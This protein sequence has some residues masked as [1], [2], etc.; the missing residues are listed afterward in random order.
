MRAL[1]RSFVLS[2]AFVLPAAAGSDVSAQ[3]VQG[4]VTVENSPNEPIEGA[5]V[6]LVD[7]A[8]G[9]AAAAF[10]T[11]TGHFLLN[12]REEG[13]YRIRVDRIGFGSWTSE[14]FN[15]T[16]GEPRSVQYGL[17]IRPVQLAEL[18]ISVQRQCWDGL[19][20]AE[21]L[22]VVWEEARK[23]LATTSF[24]Q[25]GESLR[26][27][28]LVYDRRFTEWDLG[29][30]LVE[31]TELDGYTRTPFYS[32][33]AAELSEGGYIREEDAA[34]Y[35]YAPDADV[36][37]SDPFLSDHC[38]G[39]RRA[40]RDGLIEIGLTFD[41]PE[42]RE[43]SDISGVI[44]LNEATA[45]LDRLEF[46]YENIPYQGVDDRRIGG[47]IEFIRIPNGPFVVRDWHLKMPVIAHD[48]AQ[49]GRF[50]VTDF[51]E[52]GGQ[53]RAVLEASGEPVKWRSGAAIAGFVFDS[54][55]DTPLDGATLILDPRRGDN[56]MAHTGPDGSFLFHGLEPGEYRV[57]LGH[58]RAHA[59][60]WSP[61][62]I[63]VTLAEGEER[64]IEFALPSAQAIVTRL[65][66]KPNPGEGALVG[67]VREGQARYP[68]AR[69]RVEFEWDLPPEPAPVVA[70][71]TAAEVA[72]DSTVAVPEVRTRSRSTVAD[73]DGRFRLCDVPTGIEIRIKA[74]RRSHTPTRM[75][76]T[77][78]RPIEILE[79]NLEFSPGS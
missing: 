5:F 63:S 6:V 55:S 24:V 53:I 59:L 9:S 71:D 75:T 13:T 51:T 47:T 33:P 43:L 73:Q 58:P 23:A 1:L 22:L 8:G 20:D 42:D 29:A 39:L 64:S 35:Y 38:F 65:C 60:R 36:L 10:T 16:G 25:E 30:Q 56:V 19:E 74:E 49:E 26:F 31:T 66:G 45:E 50:L 61:R 17:P 57:K 72:A 78:D 28:S 41:P 46:R 4:Q 40:E 18:D 3:V 21:E 54:I 44:W 12:A 69:T 76:V 32:L 68:L 77:L 62:D 14:E 37:L 27:N 34:I 7:G 67:H 2:V 15:L 52:F 11:E 79:V 48:P 70:A